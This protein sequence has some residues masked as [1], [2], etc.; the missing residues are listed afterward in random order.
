MLAR[1]AKR[2]KQRVDRIA[3]TNAPTAEIRRPEHLNSELLWFVTV[4]PFLI[5]AQILP[6]WLGLRA[7][8][9]RQISQPREL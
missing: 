8:V 4:T 2:A 6:D 3:E 5:L 1:A 9:N 7:A